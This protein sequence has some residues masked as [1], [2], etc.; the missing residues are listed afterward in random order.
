[1]ENAQLPPYPFESFKRMAMEMIKL[2]KLDSG[3]INYFDPE[4]Y[5]I[6]YVE[7]IAKHAETFFTNNPEVCT[8]KNIE[9]ICTGEYTE[10]EHLYGWRFGYIQLN[11]ALENFFNG[12]E[13]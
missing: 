6:K 11:E 13:I 7:D 12:E 3:G 4:S 8:L 5:E 2:I 10:N 1:M 9:N